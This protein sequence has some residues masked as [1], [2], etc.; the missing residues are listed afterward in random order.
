MHLTSQKVFLPP[1]GKNAAVPLPER[2]LQ[3]YENQRQTWNQF[4]EAYA[5]LRA[6]KTRRLECDGFPVTLQYNPNRIVSA[7]ARLDAQ[8]INARPCFLCVENLPDQQKGILFHDDFLILCNPAPIFEKHFTVSH[9]HHIEQ[10]IEPFVGV[11]LDLTRELGPSYTLFYNGPKCGASA[12]D[13]VHFQACPSDVLPV[14]SVASGERNRTF[15]KDVAH[16][17][18]WLVE[19][20]RR[21]FVV[22]ESTTHEGMGR[23]LT[24]LLSTMREVQRTTEEPLINLVCSYAD[25]AWR[26]VVFPRAKHRPE[27]YYKEGDERILVSPGAV[28]LAGCVVMPVEKDFLSV[29]ERTIGMIFREVSLDFATLSAILEKV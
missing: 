8:T 16:A 23:A 6:T 12:P 4:E 25:G 2:L 7:S 11:F 22:M 15:V 10:A 5:A 1:T 24:R 3:L 20:C 21:Q 18:V 14:L 9:I 27:V 28:D 19:N 13:H 29:D 26:L 17:S